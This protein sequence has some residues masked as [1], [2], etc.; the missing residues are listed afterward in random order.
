MS[1]ID[2]FL[3]QSCAL[4]SEAPGIGFEKKHRSCHPQGLERD[5]RLSALRSDGRSA[6]APD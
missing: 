1:F 2:G 6:G 3:V 5:Q 4:V